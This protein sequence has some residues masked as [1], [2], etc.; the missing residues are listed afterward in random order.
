MN[1]DWRWISYMDMSLKYKGRPIGKH[2][3]EYFLETEKAEEL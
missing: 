2:F 3:L 1:I